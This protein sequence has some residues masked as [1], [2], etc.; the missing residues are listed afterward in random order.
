MIMAP[1]LAVLALLS[2]ADKGET[3]VGKVIAGVTALPVSHRMGNNPDTFK[4]L[5]CV[6]TDDPIIIVT[7]PSLHCS[8]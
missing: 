4:S 1:S 2:L 5:D 8:L 7:P 6:S 3:L